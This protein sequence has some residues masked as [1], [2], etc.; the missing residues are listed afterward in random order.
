MSY[1][2][3]ALKK[4]DA[5]RARDAAVVP[6]L[7]AQS[8]A[9]ASRLPSHGIAGRG[10]GWAAATLVILAALTWWRMG[11]APDAPDAPA[12]PAVSVAPVAPLPPQPPATRLAEPAPPA[13]IAPAPAAPAPLPA[14]TATAPA[15]A[16]VVAPPAPPAPPAARAAA[17]PRAAALPARAPVAAAPAASAARVPLL[18][19]LPADVRAQLPTLAVG[20]SVYSTHAASRMVILSGQVFREGDKPADG[21]VVEQIGLKSTVLSFRGQRFELKH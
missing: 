13:V 9:G 1:I 3:D 21:L 17:P 15:A 19:E 11:A 7:H 20:G 12:A 5:E 4:A 6:D 2:L 16:V 8:D 18:A 10:L 14:A